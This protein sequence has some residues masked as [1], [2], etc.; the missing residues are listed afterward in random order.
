MTNNSLSTELEK[1]PSSR[2]NAQVEL[3]LPPRMTLVMTHIRVR[4][5]GVALRIP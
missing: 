5:V 1:E 2:E 3:I 4:N